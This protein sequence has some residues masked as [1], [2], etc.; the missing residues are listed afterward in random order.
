MELQ[1]LIRRIGREYD[2]AHGI[3]S[4]VQ[5]LLK[6]AGP[7]LQ[8]W[9]PLGYVGVGSGGMGSAATIPWVA[10]FDPDETTT[11]QRGMYVVYLFSADGSRVFLALM[12]GVTEMIDLLGRPAGREK[13]RAQA[14]AI[15]QKVPEESRSGLG[16]TVD[17]RSSVAL[18]VNYA[19]GIIFSVE[20]LI[21]DLPGDE[22]LVRDLRDM[23]HLYQVCVEI[24][25]QL[26]AA[27]AEAVVTAPPARQSPTPSPEFKPKDDSDYKQQIAARVVV[28]TRKHE[29]LVKS[30]GQFLQSRSFAVATNVHPRDMTAGQESVHWLIEAKTVDRGNGVK[31]VRDAVGQLLSY[32]FFLYDTVE[33]ANLLAVFNEPVGN[34]CVALLDHLEIAAVW[35]RDG[36]WVGSKAAYEAGLCTRVG[37]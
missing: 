36:E 3:R 15:R 17:L 35:S 33:L 14:A 22:I 8:Y 32:R 34:G 28:K 6:Q 13:L 27:G 29:T 25:E 11:A 21:D 4:P 12:Q 7:K 26:R 16:E 18:A 20:Y 9:A 2:Q 23:I 31:A 5:Q 24:R 19:A 30:Y 10:L 1:D 37:G